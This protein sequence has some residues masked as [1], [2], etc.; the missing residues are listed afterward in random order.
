MGSGDKIEFRHQLLQEYYAAEYLLR[1]LPD[2]NDDKLKRN[3]LN[4][5]KLTEPLALMLSLVEDETQALRVVKL[6]LNID[7]MLGARLAGEVKP[8]FQQQPIDSILEK[9]FLTNILHLD[10]KLE[11]EPPKPAFLG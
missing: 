11:A 9:K 3:Y 2:I 8:E 1:K 5:L 4:L 6:G 10:Q 7:L